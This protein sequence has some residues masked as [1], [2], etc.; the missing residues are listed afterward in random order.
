MNT[1][2]DIE[3]I[4]IIKNQYNEFLQREPDNV[5]LDHFLKL[6]SNKV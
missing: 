6:L 5:G 3:N 4:K 2:E 1:S